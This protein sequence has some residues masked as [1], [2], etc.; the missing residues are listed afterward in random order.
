M[1]KTFVPACV[2][3]TLIELLV[4]VLLLSLGILGVAAMQSQGLRYSQDAYFRTQADVLVNDLV[5][6]MRANT[7]GA[8]LGC[9]QYQGDAD[10]IRAR[11]CGDGVHAQLANAGMQEWGR[12]IVASGLPV[13]EVAVRCQGCGVGAGRL[14]RYTIQLL[15]DNARQ[16]VAVAQRDADTVMCD[17]ADKWCFDMTVLL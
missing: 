2:G 13:P 17:R 8:R 7:L 15:W 11:G 1:K 9:Y 5:G 16:T 6:R 3:F 12:A 4:A 14:P 10:S